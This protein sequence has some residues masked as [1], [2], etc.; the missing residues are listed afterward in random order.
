FL[1]ERGPLLARERNPPIGLDEI[2]DE[3]LELPRQLL[4][5]EGDRIRQVPIGRE[6]GAALLEAVDERHRLA[7]ERVGLAWRCRAE[8]RLQGDVAKILQGDD[9][10]GV[11]VIDDRRH[12]ERDLLEELGYVRER[13]RLENEWL[14]VE[15]D[16]V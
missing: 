10:Q 13:K 7:I 14:R 9:P 4:D 5:V 12:R 3:E 1:A 8:V 6:L 2:L 15:R 11:R 16:H